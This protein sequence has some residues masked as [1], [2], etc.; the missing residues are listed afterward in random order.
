MKSQHVNSM[1]YQNSASYSEDNAFDQTNYENEDSEFQHDYLYENDNDRQNEH[2]TL[3][4][5]NNRHPVKKKRQLSTQRPFQRGNYQRPN[6]YQQ[7]YQQQNYQRPNY[8]RSQPST[9][10]SDWRNPK[11]T[12]QRKNLPKT[13]RNPLDKNGIQIRCTIRQSINHWSQNCPDNVNTEHNTYVANE[14]VLRQTDDDN[15]QEP[16]TNH[17]NSNILCQK[18]GVQDYLIVV[19]VRQFV[20]SNG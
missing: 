9:T 15:Q 5:R 13:G 16:M 18:L 6:Y 12:V 19:L 1:T 14:V 10:N 7:N 4:T 17:K 3:Y 20:V 8:Q 2:H 11:Q